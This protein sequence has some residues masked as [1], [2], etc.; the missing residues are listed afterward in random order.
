MKMVEPVTPVFTPGDAVETPDGRGEVQEVDG[1]NWLV[2]AFPDGSS[3]WYD[4]E[5]VVPVKSSR[6][7]VNNV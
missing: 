7:G 2:V 1:D 6:I 5:W 4:P 3:D